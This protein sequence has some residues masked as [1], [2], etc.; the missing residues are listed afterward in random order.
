MATV[1]C[2]SGLLG[3]EIRGPFLVDENHLSP[4]KGH[5]SQN[6]KTAGLRWT[7]QFWDG[8]LMIS[9]SHKRLKPRFSIFIKMKEILSI[10]LGF[11]P[12]IVSGAISGPSLFR[13]MQPSCSP[14]LVLIM[15]YKQLAKGFILTWGSL[16]FFGFNLVMVVLFGNLWV[17][18]TWIS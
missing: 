1:S 16:L 7:P 10:L 13:L 5:D 17:S 3:E 14:A 9:P 2:L 6:G 8:V 4:L 12:W 15:G 18:K 11:L